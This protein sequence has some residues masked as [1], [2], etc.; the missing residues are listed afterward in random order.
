MFLFISR[1]VHDDLRLWGPNM[2]A[3]CELCVSLGFIG[4]FLSS[5]CLTDIC[6]S[7]HI[8]LSKL[9]ENYVWVAFIW[10][11][12]VQCQIGVEK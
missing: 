10:L 7:I 1:L 8:K 9:S 6:Q 4:F 12:G 11:L 2:H 5:G 3:F